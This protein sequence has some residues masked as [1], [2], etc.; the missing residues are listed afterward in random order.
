[1]VLL[2]YKLRECPIPQQVLWEDV[3]QA[4][5]Q[6]KCLQGLFLL[7]IE[8]EVLESYHRVAQIWIQG[9]GFFI[10]CE[11]RFIMLVSRILPVK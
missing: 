6:P 9:P 4:S 5:G 11:D 3:V 2:Y 7:Q 8:I 10:L 1:M